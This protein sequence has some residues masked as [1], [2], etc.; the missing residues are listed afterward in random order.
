MIK[1]HDFSG[2]Q[3]ATSSR[4]NF[5]NRSQSLA[6][7]I[8]KINQ[9]HSSKGSSSQMWKGAV[10]SLRKRSMF[11]PPNNAAIVSPSRSNIKSK[12]SMLS[13]KRKTLTIAENSSKSTTEHLQIFDP[14]L[15]PRQQL[16]KMKNPSLIEPSVGLKQDLRTP[17][18]KLL[19][20]EQLEEFQSLLGSKQKWRKFNEKVRK[21][22][23]Q[24][25]LP[26]FSQQTKIMAN[27]NQSQLQTSQLP[28]IPKS[29]DM[30]DFLEQSFSKQ[31]TAEHIRRVKNVSAAR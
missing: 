29:T 21:G 23:D 2:M 15:A 26:Y 18:H 16:P 28:A 17:L 30:Q 31:K 24:T 12:V 9:D 20:S 14:E 25:D 4:T 11:L 22:A 1:E 19:T 6:P 7:P 3:L 13:K 10:S 5:A 27:V 8:A